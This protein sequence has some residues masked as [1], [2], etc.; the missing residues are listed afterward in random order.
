V[1]IDLDWYRRK[2]DRL[3]TALG[4]FGYQMA[5]PGGA[6]YLWVKAPG[7]DDIA[8]VH[9]LRKMRVLAVPGIGFGTSGYF[10][11]AYCVSDQIIEGA[12]PAFEK[13]IT[14]LG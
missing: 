7:G 11:I 2:R 9:R 14:S 5:S 6:F 4:A 12:L 13:A 1:T 8:F 3:V 10:R